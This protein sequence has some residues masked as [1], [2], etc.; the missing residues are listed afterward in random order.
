MGGLGPGHA[1]RYPAATVTAPAPLELGDALEALVGQFADPWSFLREMIQNSIDAGSLEIEIC[2]EHDVAESVMTIEII[3]NGEGMDREIIDTRLTRLFSSAKDGDYTKIGRFGI[4]FVSVFAIDPDVVCV[5]TARAGQHWRILFRRDRSFERILLDAPGEGTTVRIYCKADE[6]AYEAARIRALATLRYWCRYAHVEIR[7]NGESMSERLGV[8]SICSARLEEE[9]SEV[10]VGLWPEAEAPRGYYHG[11]LTLHE[12][13][14][15][16]GS[17]PYLTFKI[18]SRFL[19]HTLTRDN[20][21]RDENYAKAMALVERAASGPLLV[22]LFA[23]LGQIAAGVR[24]QR[25][26]DQQ[27]ALCEAAIRHLNCGAQLPGECRTLPVFPTLGGAPISIS[28]LETLQGELHCDR[29]RSPVTDR[30]ASR[31]RPVLDAAIGDGIYRL[32]E[33]ITGVRASSANTAL[34]LAA[35]APNAAEDQRWHDFANA[36]RGLLL[37][38]G[39]KLGGI[40]IGDLD[41]PGSPVALRVAISQRKLGELTPVLE[42]SRLGRS[43][44][45]SARFVVLNAGHAL[46]KS[47]LIGGVVAAEPELAAY[48]VT[49]LLYLREELSPERDGHLARRAMEGRCRRLTS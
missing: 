15:G 41:Y 21:I 13:V 40:A 2:V 5:D 44:F 22:A 8:D 11:G 36:V 17:I 10:V 24:A 4:G 34:C 45:S 23:Q 35:A 9:G 19:E 38:D 25:D 18:D 16:E 49:K 6:P 3:D 1:L 39:V 42:A 31:G 46:L 20:V 30:L 14:G 37:A 26:E 43:L 7:F 28:E 12:E 29:I 33:A 48:L 32:A 27:T 47:L